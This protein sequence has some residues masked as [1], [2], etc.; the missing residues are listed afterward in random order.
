M[1][2]G[3]VKHYRMQERPTGCLGVRRKG[4]VAVAEGLGWALSG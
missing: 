1:G 4:L 3:E 2:Y